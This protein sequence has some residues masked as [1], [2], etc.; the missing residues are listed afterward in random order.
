MSKQNSALLNDPAFYRA[1]IDASMDG[2]VII[3]E[4]QQIILMNPVSL[5]MF[6]YSESEVLEEKIEMLIPERFRKNHVEYVRAFGSGMHPTSRSMGSLGT[7]YALRKNGEEFPLE[8]SISKMQVQGKPLYAVI[9]RDITLRFEYEKKILGLTR[10]HAVQSGV[11][12]S[13]LRIRDLGKLFEEVGRI[14]FE[15]G[16]FPAVWLSLYSSENSN[17]S[18]TMCLGLTDKNLPLNILKELGTDQHS[19]LLSK[20]ITEQLPIIV[21]DFSEKPY[22]SNIWIKTAKT[23]GLHSLILMPLQVEGITRGIFLVF[24]SEKNFFSEEEAELLNE[25]AGDISFAML[26]SEKQTRVS[27]LSN[28]DVLT[29]LANRKVFLDRLDQ[30]IDDHKNNG[31]KVAV[32]IMNIDRFKSINDTF[33]RYAGD[34]LL[35]QVVERFER[36]TDDKQLRHA[37]LSGDIFAILIPEM[38]DASQVA[39]K[40]EYKLQRY[41]STP[42]LIRDTELMV[43]A[44]FG[45]AMFPDDGET[46][47]EL[48]K[49]AESALKKTRIRR[50]QYLFY[51]ER[52]N[53]RVAEQLNIENKL[54][55]AIAREEF[56]LHY[57]P[58]VRIDSRK[59]IGAEALIRWNDPEVGLVPPGRFIPV[60]EE[61]GLMLELCHWILQRSIEDS[62]K[63]VDLGLE[64]PNLSINISDR[65]LRQSHFIEA[66]SDAFSAKK[67]STNI[68]LE[69][70][71][72]ML[73]ENIDNNITKLNAIKEMGISISLDDFGTGY[74]SLAY[75]AKLPIDTLKI[76]RG[77]IS[78]MLENS[79][80]MALV[81]TIINLCQTLQLD[82]IAEG[83]EL[84]E[85]AKILRLLRCNQMQ[86]FLF[87]KPLPL[88]EFA[89]LLS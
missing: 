74:S 24:A 1:L 81:S 61:T 55:R 88:D 31:L 50:D 5:E 20:L 46:A 86:G 44:K 57:Q 49:N 19:T 66:I 35:I 14:V 76:D 47:E 51:T 16:K 43:S 42:Y 69:I 71:E 58:K 23:L 33:G 53:D 83:V 84:E 21:D 73:M 13:I 7:V 37:R 26:Y 29:G 62:N 38:Q 25:V 48:F 17:I 60:L 27:Y 3:D 65:Q 12:N 9:L 32:L 52:M 10:L 8:A 68:E 41:F 15:E 22:S 59:I 78:S 18:T 4:Q 45:V 80:S 28:Y 36:G 67:G 82:V 39:Q 63:L 6:G 85:Q 87:S 11:N 56:I 89:E 79:N 77:F 2:F 70:T 34:E 40:I 75:L 30:Y 72:S 64:L 54:R